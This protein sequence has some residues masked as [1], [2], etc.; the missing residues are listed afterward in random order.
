MVT[1]FDRIV[2]A[3]G[4][5]KCHALRMRQQSKMDCAAARMGKKKISLK[6]VYGKEAKSCWTYSQT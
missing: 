1:S 3:A 2:V 4:R 5:P 6:Y